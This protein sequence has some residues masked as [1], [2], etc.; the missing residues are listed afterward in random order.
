[1]KCLIRVN[2]ARS[3][4]DY[5]IGVTCVEYVD[6]LPF[7]DAVTNSC[8]W[9]CQGKKDSGYQ[10]MRKKDSVSYHTVCSRSDNAQAKCS[11]ISL[12]HGDIYI[13]SLSQL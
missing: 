7:A 3:A 10:K 6:E 8:S 2:E 5:E 1:M 13:F 9:R 12:Q 4:F 11:I